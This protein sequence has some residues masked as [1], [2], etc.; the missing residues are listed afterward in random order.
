MTQQMRPNVILVPQGAEYQ[1]VQR[2]LQSVSP[3]PTV[4][5]VPVGPAPLTQFLQTWC[6]THEL[7][8][9][10]V[11][12]TGLCGSLSPTHPEASIVLYQGCFGRWGRVSDDI[13]GEN[14]PW[15]PCD[16]D[17][18]SSLW[19]I[20]GPQ[21]Q[22]VRAVTCDRMIHRVADKLQLGQ[23]SGAEV[24]DMEGF[25]VLKVLQAAGVP[26]AMVRVVS[27]GC[28]GDVPDLSA[29]IGADGSLRPLPLAW[30]MVRQPLAAARL[31]RG[32]LRGL[33]QLEQLMG[34]IFRV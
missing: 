8:Q 33:R 12:V 9:Q 22:S 32:S 29:A 11:L 4:V 30:G 27:D 16:A 26:V 1:A 15:R 21:V 20:L 3:Q 5:S 28:T 31:V 24:V 19:T 10:R 6:R 18:T 2:G 25:A 34:Q 23:Q 7:Q 17:L 13:F 14:V